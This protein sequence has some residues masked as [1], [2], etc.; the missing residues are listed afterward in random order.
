LLQSATEF[1]AR[2]TMRFHSTTDP[3]DSSVQGDR[4]T[5]GARLSTS[6]C[7]VRTVARLRQALRHA[8][9]LKLDRDPWRQGAHGNLNERDWLS[10]WKGRN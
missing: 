6:S 1:A 3:F 9:S 5:I 8:G 4:A 7:L 2:H 10:L